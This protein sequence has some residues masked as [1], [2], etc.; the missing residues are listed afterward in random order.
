MRSIWFSI[1][2]FIINGFHRIHR[3]VLNELLFIWNKSKLDQS[4]NKTESHFPDDL[5]LVHFQKISFRQKFSSIMQ[6]F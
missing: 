4:I 1:K 5:W 6:I 2:E 3:K